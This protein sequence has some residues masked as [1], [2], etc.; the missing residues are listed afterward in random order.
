[1]FRFRRSIQFLV[2]GCVGAL[3]SLAQ[4]SPP[5]APSGSAAATPDP[6][7]VAAAAAVASGKV[8]V[9]TPD[10]LE[11]LVD[12]LLQIFDVRTSGNTTTHYVIAGLF[13]LG[14]IVL[15]GVVTRMLFGVLKTFASRTKTT[16]DDKLFAALA[17]PVG[18][19]I[20]YIG[21]LASL[22]VLKLPP[23]SDLAVAYTSTVV[24]SFIIFWL[25]LRAFNTVLEHLQDVARERKM[26]VAAFMPWIR[27][28]LLTIFVI[29]GV[30]MVAQSLG[31]DVKA[32]LAGLGIGGLAVA[33]AAQ[34]T[35]AN[36]FGSVVVAVDQP[37]R[38][39][40]FVRIGGNSG[41]VEDIGLRSTKLRGADKSL[42][43]IPNRTVAAEA[44]TNL[45][46]FTQRRFEQVIGLTYTT[47]PEQMEAIVTEFRELIRRDEEVDPGSV[48]VFFRDF[49]ASSLDIWVAYM[50]KDADFEKS[51]RLK[52]RIN[53]EFMR[54]VQRRGL[55]FA[56][57]SQ[58]L[59]IEGD[60]GRAL[61]ARRDNGEGQPVTRTNAPSEA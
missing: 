50:T 3:S 25:L 54:A 19:L 7:T 35:I 49:S 10:F 13:L 11:H 17:A 39:G 5:P 15:R 14:A 2:L 60:V 37:F 9:H 48:L 29:F 58:S 36:I 43:V 38:I 22:K 8:D 40:E 51:M 56:F 32:F 23:S 47:T 18:A 42:T 41:T 26:G 61:A 52:Q 21:A 45:S 31:A 1:M 28:A 24:F 27:K 55:S 44:I 30:L 33:L 34:D 6:N 4:E 46:R 12:G 57:P 59:Y 16:L 53:T 20:I